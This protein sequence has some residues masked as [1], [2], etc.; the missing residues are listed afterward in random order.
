MKKW[1]LFLAI[2]FCVCLLAACGAAGSGAPVSG[3]TPSGEEQ[4]SGESS[5]PASVT[6]VCRV[7]SNDGSL[8]LAGMDG[9][10]SI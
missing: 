3:G 8:L 9:D 10:S 6:A 2:Y 1:P 5:Q 7:V 4:A